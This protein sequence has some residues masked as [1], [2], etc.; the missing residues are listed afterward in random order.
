MGGSEAGNDPIARPE[1]RRREWWHRPFL[2]MWALTL[3]ATAYAS[4]KGAENILA[5]YRGDFLARLSAR[6]EAELIVAMQIFPALIAVA[7]ATLLLRARRRKAAALM[8]IS[9]LLLTAVD[10][11]G[12]NFTQNRLPLLTIL[13]L[14]NAGWC[15]LIVS[16]MIFPD[17]R[18][19]SPWSR[20]AAA[21]A[22]G[23]HLALVPIQLALAGATA[24]PALYLGELVRAIFFGVGV[25]SL[26]DR[27]KET[28]AGRRRHLLLV[29][30]VSLS[31]AASLISAWAVMNITSVYFSNA[32]EIRWV[33]ARLLE[34]G[35]ACFGIGFLVALLRYGLYDAERV[36]SRSASVAILAALVLALF[37]AATLLLSAVWKGSHP[38]V[39]ALVPLLLIAPLTK[40][41]TGWVDRKLRPPLDDLRNKLPS[42]VADLRHSARL[43]ELLDE[44]AGRIRRAVNPEAVAFLIGGEP[45]AAWDGNAD[46]VRSWAKSAS[47]DPEAAAPQIDRNDMRY[48]LRIPLR[49]GGHAA[50]PLVGWLLLGPQQDEIFYDPDEIKALAGLSAPIARA[51]RA[52][53]LR[54]I[55][56]AGRTGWAD[57]GKAL[58]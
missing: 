12:A 28:P 46:A 47:L 24:T 54:P 23:V 37:Q 36:I 8:S 32:R 25:I 10:F 26:L 41:V 18:F 56:G 48:P 15:G 53:E 22:V 27:L 33:G 39:A 6:Q 4:Y 9:L 38:L 17:G 14:S 45:A 16:F 11:A 49:L 57:R 35:F 29:A 55:E 19:A 52:I 3:G 34:L 30:I 43:P 13:G 58:G 50:S 51:I 5:I 7:V 31:A 1:A 42:D 20:R 40:V 44:V 21:I 2:A